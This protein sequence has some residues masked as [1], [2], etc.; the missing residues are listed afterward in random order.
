[1]LNSTLHV[2]SSGKFPGWSKIRNTNSK[3]IVE[4]SMSRSDDDRS[5]PSTSA[6]ARIGDA[7]TSKTMPIAANARR[8]VRL[9]AA[10][11]TAASAA[12]IATPDST[13]LTSV[14]SHPAKP[15]GPTPSTV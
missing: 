5:A 12:E 4:M 3:G 8:S 2:A 1:M 13:I 14:Q 10:I 6:A 9:D 7:R 15:S 11:D